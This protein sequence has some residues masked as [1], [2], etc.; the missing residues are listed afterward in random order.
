[1]G[2]LDAS[3]GREEWGRPS[4]AAALGNASRKNCDATSPAS[5][6]VWDR[7]GQS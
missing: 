4:T 2:N 5:L 3:I 1:M 7:V 6:K